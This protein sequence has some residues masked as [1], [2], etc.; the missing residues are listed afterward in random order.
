[1]SYGT[2]CQ[3]AL[4]VGYDGFSEQSQGQFAS[5]T[6][7]ARHTTS[8]R[9]RLRAATP[10]SCRSLRRRS[11]AGLLW[12]SRLLA[13]AFVSELATPLAVSFQVYWRARIINQTSG[14]QSLG[15]K[16]C[17]D[18]AAR[19]P[20]GPL[21]MS[22]LPAPAARQR[23]SPCCRALMSAQS[24]PVSL[25]FLASVRAR[26]SAR[27]ASC[28]CPRGD[29]RLPPARALATRPSYPGAPFGEGSVV[30]FQ[31]RPCLFDNERSHSVRLALGTHLDMRAAWRTLRIQCHKNLICSVL[32]LPPSCSC[33]FLLQP[34]DSCL[35]Q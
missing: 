22:K 19:A 27:A 28:R 1:M 16:K 2:Y 6:V 30:P 33:S 25:Y 15:G 9:R 11:A 7:E 21:A 10:G 17:I 31:H 5:T 18:F 32:P 34:P 23:V 13:N 14:G 12:Y 3:T 26:A 8:A 20:G 24:K 29:E 35:H 4:I